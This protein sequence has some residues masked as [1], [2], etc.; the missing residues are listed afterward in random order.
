MI[1]R[2]ATETAG[3]RLRKT[4]FY[5]CLPDVPGMVWSWTTRREI[6]TL[7]SSREEAE[8]VARTMIRARTGV[9]VIQ[10]LERA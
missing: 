9:R 8:R 1:V 6:A 3:E 10:F 2:D 5:V 4:R 7:F